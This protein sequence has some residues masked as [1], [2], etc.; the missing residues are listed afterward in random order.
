VRLV[1]AVLAEQDGIAIEVF[2]EQI[3]GAAKRVYVRGLLRDG[4]VRVNTMPA[5]PRQRLC[6]ADVVEIRLV[7]RVE[8]VPRH[9][10]ARAV[11]LTVL[12]EDDGCL[13]VD[14]PAGLPTVPDRS[15]NEPSVHGLLASRFPGADLRIVH[16][17]DRDTS[18]CL[19]LARGVEPARWFD[20]A[21]REQ[22]VAK[23][24]L[25]LVVG[26]IDRDAFEVE[27]WLGPDK[28]QAT[29]MRVAAAGA[30]KAR[31]THTAFAVRERFRTMTLLEARPT[32]GRTHQIRVHLASRRHPLVVD[33]LYGGS[34][35]LYLSSIK[36]G[37]RLPVG[38][39]ERPLI[40]RLTLHAAAVAFTGPNGNRVA[41]ESPLPTDFE[42]ALKKVRKYL[43]DTEPARPT[44]GER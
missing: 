18:G 29:R 7:D 40:E 33:P 4:R 13:V 27:D 35:A 41:V 20:Q 19:I 44:D 2:V 10:V 36:A 15:G 6:E 39:R 42:L 17:L 38:R 5:A 25:A 11:E 23:R 26:R 43:S 31:A 37:Y 1:Q 3:L 21:F 9:G 34:E 24:Y 8:D 14:K 12:H 16:R 28:P 30:K 22:A 32:T